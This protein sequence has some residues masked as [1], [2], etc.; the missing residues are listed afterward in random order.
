MSDFDSG[1]VARDGALGKVAEDS[2]SP[3]PTH[4]GSGRGAMLG[5]LG[6]PVILVALIA[7][8]AIT[9]GDFLSADNIKA[10]FTEAAFPAIIAVGLTVCLAMGEFDLSLSGVAGLATV[11]VAVLVARNHMGAIPAILIT[12]AAVGA[13]VG[14]FNGFLV[15]YLGLNALIVTIAV[16]SGLIG[17]EYVVSESKQVFGGFPPGFSNFCRGDIGPVPTIVVLAAGLALAVWVMIEHT[18]LGRHMRAVGGN[19]EAARIAGV[20]TA[21]TKVYGFVLC[22]LMA[23]IAGVLFAG[24]QTT[25]YPQSGLELLLPSYAACFIGAATIKVGEFNVFGT[26]IGVMIAVITANG[27]LLMGVANYATFLIQGGILLVALL[28][29]RAVAKRQGVS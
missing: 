29:A 11:L 21:R 8:F 18:T 13:M 22:S 7:I 20:N 15:G 27:L 25:A 5:Q 28:F 16:N 19:V 6:V 23:A 12:L 9:A 2:P 4:Q 14:A 3:E 17:M 1:V 10:I 24:K 26:L